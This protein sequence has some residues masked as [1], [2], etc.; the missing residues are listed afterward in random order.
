MI[1]EERAQGEPS[2][3]AWS[4]NVIFFATFAISLTSCLKALA[5]SRKP[6]TFWQR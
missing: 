5:L 4:V 2:K 6:E 1:S 3:L